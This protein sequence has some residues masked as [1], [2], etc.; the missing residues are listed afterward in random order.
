M[1]LV[2]HRLCRIAGHDGEAQPVFAVGALGIGAHR[3]VEAVGVVADEDPPP[4]W[5]AAQGRAK[6]PQSGRGT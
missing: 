5:R 2:D 6:R 4:F 1:V 3:L